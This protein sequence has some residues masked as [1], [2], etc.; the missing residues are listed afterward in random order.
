MDTRGETTDRPRGF[1]FLSIGSIRLSEAGLHLGEE[2]AWKAP[3][4]VPRKLHVP[5]QFRRLSPE[6]NNGHSVRL[7]KNG[8]F[9]AL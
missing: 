1:L 8:D 7:D 2:R 6:T 4:E 3:L 9:Q 5:R